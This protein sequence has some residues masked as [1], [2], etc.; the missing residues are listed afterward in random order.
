MTGPFIANTVQNKPKYSGLYTG[1]VVS[2]A[3]ELNMGRL[4]IKIPELLG[5]TTIWANPLIPFGG[6]IIQAIPPVKQEVKV[7]FQG[8]IE[9]CYWLG[10][11]TKPRAEAM[12][13]FLIFSCFIFIL[14]AI[15]N[16]Y[17]RVSA[18]KLR[19]KMEMAKKRR[20]KSC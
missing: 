12:P 19:K 3:D 1:V 11:S 9:D 14:I 10:G 15:T 5:E 20:E 13:I 8:S 17:Y 16:I 2:Q 4:E 18:A 7:W 6:L